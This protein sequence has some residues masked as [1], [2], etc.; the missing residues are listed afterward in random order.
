MTPL[1]G[2]EPNILKT[3]DVPTG[4][5][6]T[7][8]F[9]YLIINVGIFQTLCYNI[10]L[11]PLYQNYEHSENLGLY[12]CMFPIHELLALRIYARIK[13]LPN[14]RKKERTN[15]G[16]S[17]RAKST[18]SCRI[19]LKRC[20]ATEENE[21]RPNISGRPF[22]AD[23]SHC[24]QRMATPRSRIVLFFLYDRINRKI[25]RHQPWSDG[26]LVWRPPRY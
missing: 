24:R 13:I 4:S 19:V 8:C 12:T 25:R 26:R 20:G 14:S 9:L 22:L 23:G 18:R 15:A 7:I 11:T 10:F 5:T 6:H 3:N 2:T 16:A 1:T 21:S 17:W